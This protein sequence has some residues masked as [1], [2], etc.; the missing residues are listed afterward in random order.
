MEFK[1][2]DETV[3]AGKFAELVSAEIENGKL[4]LKI[5][6]PY[7]EIKW[8]YFVIGYLYKIASDREDYIAEADS[9]TYNGYEAVLKGSVDIEKFPFKPTNWY[10][11]V[12]YEEDG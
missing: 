1:R 10:V 11:A 12:A 6:A 3:E 4:N 9:V 7:T 5:S 8:K 2:F